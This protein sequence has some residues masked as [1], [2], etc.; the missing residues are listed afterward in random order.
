MLHS[1]ASHKTPVR[2]KAVEFGI[3]S[4]DEIRRMAVCEIKNPLLYCKGLPMCEGVIDHRMGPCDRR[5][6][7]G[8]CN[9]S[10]HDCPGHCGFIDL[11]VPM[12]H[13]FNDTCLKILR[14]VCYSCGRLLSGAGTQRHEEAGCG[15]VHFLGVY[16]TARGKKQCPHCSAP[17]PNYVRC[18]GGNV[19][20]IR[21]EWP[22]DAAW[23]SDDEKAE[24]TSR[25]FTSIEAA[26]ILRSIPD[27]DV[28][29]MGL[30]PERTH[31]AWMIP[32]VILVPP[33]STRPAI[34]SS[35]GSRL[36]GQDDLT[37]KLNDINKRAADLRA[38]IK[39]TGWTV[40]DGVPPAMLEKMSK[41][42]VEISTMLSNSASVQK[43]SSGQRSSAPTKSLAQRLRGKEG[44]IRGN[45]MGKRVDFSARSVITPDSLMA[46][47]DV[48]VP[49]SVAKEL[50]V[51]EKV[52][53]HNIEALY[54][55]VLLGTS[56]VDGAQSVA[57]KD[58]VVQ[59]QFL[60][61]TQRSQIRLQF[62]DTVERFL[63]NGDVCIFNR[64]PS[65]H[66][67]GFLGHRVK[68]YPGRTFRLNLSVTS[69]YN[70]DFDGDEMNLHACQSE[71][72][73]NEISTLMAV[74][75]QIITPQSCKPVMSIV[76]DSLIGCYLLTH[77]RMLLTRT[78]MMRL[79]VW[80]RRGTAVGT[81]P[82]SLPPPAIEHP[83]P[84]WTGV[85]AFSLVLPDALV[86][87]RLGPSEWPPDGLCIRRGQVLVGRMSKSTLG[88]G[89]GG[90]IDVMYREL[91]SDATMEYMSNVQRVVVPFLM[92]QGFSVSFRDVVV[93][94]EGRSKVAE[95]IK[96]TMHNIEAIV[97][98][99]MPESL[100]A[101]AENTVFSMLSKLLLQAGA[102]GKKY[103]LPD[104]SVAALVESGSKGNQLNVA[105][106]AGTVG[107]QSVEGQRIFSASH[108]RTLTCFDHGSTQLVS[109]GFVE[110]SYVAGLKPA[111]FF[112]HAMGGREGLVDT[113]V[114][115]AYTGYIQ[116]RMMKALE[117]LH[118][119]YVCDVRNAQGM[120]V[121]FSYG[122]DA[123]DPT[124]VRQTRLDALAK[125][126]EQL[127]RD[128]CDD[129]PTDVQLREVEKLC[130][131]VS[132]ARLAR[133]NVARPE[134]DTLTL[135]P[136]DVEQVLCRFGGPSG[137]PGGTQRHTQ[138]QQQHIVASAFEVAVEQHVDAL[139]SEVLDDQ[140]ANRTNVE[141][142]VRHRLC[143]RVLRRRGVPEHRLAE[144][145]EHIRD[146]CCDSLVCPGE[147]CG[148]IGAQSL[149]QPITQ[150]TL[151]SFH[152][153]GIASKGMTQGVPRLKEILDAS[154]TPKTPVTTFWLR[155]PLCYDAAFAASFAR[156]LPAI[157][158]SSIVRRTDVLFEPDACRTD[159]E[160]DAT[161]VAMDAYFHTPRPDASA[162]VARLV[163]DKDE[164]RSRD[165]TPPYLQHLLDDRLNFQAHIISSEV[166]SLEWVLR[167]RYHHVSDM[168][169]MI[170]T[171]ASG[172][173]EES[174]VRRVTNM[175]L[176][177]ITVS[178]HA[179]ISG[180]YERE[181][182]AWNDA[183]ECNET[184]YVVD[185]MGSVL[186]HA[187]L[188]PVVDATRSTSTDPHEVA[189]CLGIEA[190][191]A[192]IHHET[193][194]VLSYDS[195]KVEKR[196]VQLVADAMTHRGFI[197]PMSRHGMNRPGNSCGAL[198]QASFEETADVLVEAATF[199]KTDPAQGV[200]VSVMTGDESKIIGTGAF[201]VL[202]PEESLV[203]H[204]VPSTEPPRRRLVKST[205]RCGTG[206]AGD[207]GGAG[208]AGGKGDG[209][210][211]GYVDERLWRFQSSG[212][213]N[214][215]RHPFLDVEM[216][217]DSV[218]IGTTDRRAAYESSEKPAKRI[219]R[220]VPS[221]PRGEDE[222]AYRGSE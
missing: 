216:Q 142:A 126:H 194:A 70:A 95:H 100:R 180:A 141:V 44:R 55:R 193:D 50:T 41:L 88:T 11:G 46:V 96:S 81:P 5:L 220:Y 186:G 190:A 148:S 174:L 204:A 120:V 197:V 3:L 103:M 15:K 196:H 170:G 37:L 215:M 221:S 132:K 54:R 161:I 160:A 31:P 222:E 13:N 2:T 115:T 34:M 87:D 77:P 29:A 56:S 67:I 213:T 73:R 52:T 181:L 154:Q 107:Q 208:G 205:V 219:D 130:R 129:R 98:A 101:T 169:K 195:S 18:A 155:S 75:R 93:T 23:S 207:V 136:F 209:V 69:P 24:V 63:A 65:L 39:T 165:L 168:V 117:D 57:T 42:Q 90:I 64:Q 124:L 210:V 105:Q 14:S 112:F 211:V 149:G 91:G 6:R 133:Q 9:Q 147:A 1:F 38:Y 51:P 45:L 157:T 187:S 22:E 40:A 111:A 99:E 66:R 68:L 76:Q 199:A 86:I 123:W 218:V 12:Y 72:A 176:D 8:T 156:T 145:F 4:P 152:H 131:V 62:G 104:S 27:E 49:M 94:D 159:V 36:R 153:S 138:E 185:V 191:M 146:K 82:L 80:V 106:I 206:D 177:Q 200:T 182:Q 30:D 47:G 71:C 125:G 61:A 28:R 119:T 118:N 43:A 143:S 151:N 137:A 189:R 214:G 139:C 202:V 166:N 109:N 19:N 178:G 217:D 144:L 59:L 167:M 7:C 25:V 134:M 17:Q 113:A 135:L 74:G 121:Q 114:K 108:D 110:S 78:Q 85:Q 83:G 179:G 32:D 140:P 21:I 201:D 128:L 84:F 122:L 35:S 127:R 26:S 184:V 163:L 10:V 116:R 198:V 172:D 16:A 102:I 48:G 150:M 79:L 97:N 20:A 192:T 203:G 53:S 171:E 164:M 175:L 58:G 212:E 162:Y 188:F 60:D 92:A 89:S 173:V 33:S 158:L 183:K